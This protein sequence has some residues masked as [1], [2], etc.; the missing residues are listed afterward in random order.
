MKKFEDY[1]TARELL[2]QLFP[3]ADERLSLSWVYQ[4]RR[5]GLIPSLM[6]GGCYY[7]DPEAVRKKLVKERII[8]A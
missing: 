4:A 6:K 7:F 1:V 8:S 3:N 2:E 5:T